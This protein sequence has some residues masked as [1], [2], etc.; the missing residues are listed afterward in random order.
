MS[1]GK[2]WD[3]NMVL[4]VSRI[5]EKHDCFFYGFVQECKSNQ[6]FVELQFLNIQN[7]IYS[8]L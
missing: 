4:L 5:Q 6:I 8:K 7:P 2:Y 3:R 1:G